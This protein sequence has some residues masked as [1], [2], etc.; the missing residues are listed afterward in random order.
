MR[1]TINQWNYI[2][3]SWNSEALYFTGKEFIQYLGIFYILSY[4]WF[5]FH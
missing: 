3:E 5:P 1:N 4:N 2:T